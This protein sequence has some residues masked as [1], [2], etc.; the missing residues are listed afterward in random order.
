MQ[1]LIKISWRNIWRNPQRSLV[2]IIAIT[3]GLWGGIFAA[4]LSFG[5][6]QQ[7]FRSSIEQQV[8][9]V[10][11]HHPDF[12]LDH[13]VK[14]TLEP[15]NTIRQQLEDD[16]D[17]V[18]F[19]GRT[20]AT[21]MLG[22]ANLTTGVSIFGIDPEM[23]AATTRLD[24]NIMEGEFFGQDLR[25]P[26]LI[27]R[28]L[29]DKI[30]ARPGSRVVL[31]FLDVEG[32]LTSAS[33]RVAGIYQTAN[34]ALDEQNVYVLRS[35]LN[36]LLGSTGTV[37]EAAILLSDY[38]LSEGFADRYLEMFPDMK[39]RHWAEISPELSYLHEMAG[40]ML[41]IVLIIILLALSFGLLNTMLMSVFERVKELG[42]LM[43]IGMNKRRVFFMILLETGFLT[44]TGAAGGVMMSL[45][46]ILLLRNQG[47]D[48]SAV[49]GDTMQQFGFDTVIYPTLEPSFFGM[50]TILVILTA[51][52]T[53]I[54]PAMK[55]LKLRPAEAVKGE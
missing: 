26:V 46:T 55:A 8:S 28:K 42:M 9:H 19:T 17:V 41:M 50:L 44:I 34:L 27:G 47:L 33:F 24:N 40:V 25:L 11:M 13:N 1:M 49:G 45:L 23:E 6:L 51:V 3:A 20:R 18:T 32:E 48:L 14:Y 4:S 7:R 43:A 16:P 52:L 12:L 36:E 31:T 29:A 53:S 15:W 37:N 38:N 39:I 10:Q 5:M 35:D 54:Y 2:M 21:G 22:S 30:K